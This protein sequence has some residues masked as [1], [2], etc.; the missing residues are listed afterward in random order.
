MLLT[1]CLYVEC[2][3]YIGTALLRYVTCVLQYSDSIVLYL[4][5]V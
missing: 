5:N 1:F 2:Y 3:G 4:I